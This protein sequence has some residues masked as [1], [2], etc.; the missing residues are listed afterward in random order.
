MGKNGKK[1]PKRSRTKKAAV[2]DLDPKDKTK[3]V[4]G[5]RQIVDVIFSYT[6]R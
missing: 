1:T 5:G 3:N 6:N 2:K 4:K